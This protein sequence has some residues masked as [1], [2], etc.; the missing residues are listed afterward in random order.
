MI[1]IRAHKSL[2]AIYG[3]WIDEIHVRPDQ[4]A[5]P[6]QFNSSSPPWCG[7]FHL[8]GETS[9]WTGGMSQYAHIFIWCSRALVIFLAITSVT[10]ETTIEIAVKINIEINIEITTITFAIE[11]RTRML[12]HPYLDL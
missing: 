3:L 8:L 6:G 12:I 4:E 11:Q 5:P 10:I 9:R 1:I 2:M 7:F